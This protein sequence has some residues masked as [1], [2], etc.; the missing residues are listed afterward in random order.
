MRVVGVVGSLF[1]LAACTAPMPETSEPTE[2][3]RHS[4]VGGTVSPSAQDATVLVVEAGSP[5]CTGIL[6]APSLVLTAR[7][8][9][10]YYNPTSECGAPLGAEAPT[11][12]I[13][14]SV[15]VYASPHSPAARATRFFVPS[16]HDLCSDDIALIALD[17]D[18]PNVTPATVRFSPATVDEI[19]TAIGYGNQGS[20][21]R[22]RS[23]VK[24]LA[25]GP[26]TATYRTA[27]GQALTMNVPASE[28]ATTESTCF[29][30][31]G[32]PLL[33]SIGQVVAVASRGL[34]EQCVDRPTFWTSLA[35]HQQL[36]R[37]AAA[38]V[39]QP[40][41][42]ASLRPQR[43]GA[44]N[45]ASGSTGATHGDDA[46]EEDEEGGDAPAK[47]RSRIGTV[48][49]AGCA[50][51]GGRS[52]APGPLALGIAVAWWMRRRRARGP[53]HERSGAPRRSAA[54]S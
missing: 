11:S 5:T 30:D 23:D 1:A 25:V 48:A 36:I 37:S 14:V 27:T 39:G 20:G 12:L 8:C 33:D 7:H 17:K 52:Q 41:T 45:A 34:D 53:R 10:T 24:V 42:E 3:T 4:I 9:V 22:E 51:A 26:A 15:G 49:S 16:A 35:A 31:S 32:G 13:T 44:T 2:A 43:N 6:V 29:G 19:T 47:K 18:V 54:P 28:V 38:A 50:L 46:T 40:L 21:R